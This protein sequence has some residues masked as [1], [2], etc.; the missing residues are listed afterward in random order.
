M[1]HA[2]TLNNVFLTTDDTDRNQE[3]HGSNES[4]GELKFRASH[5]I[6]SV[7]SVVKKTSRRERISMVRSTDG[8]QREMH[9]TFC[10]FSFAA[11]RQAVEQAGFRVHPSSRVYVNPWLI[12]NRYAGKVQLFAAP[13]DDRGLAPLPW[14]PT[15]MVL[16][17]E[18]PSS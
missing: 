11:W 12:E 10:F 8:R 9:E 5:P 6:L 14:P 7:T 17:A 15:N 3:D 1:S 13:T 16:V 18:R 4:E 2:A